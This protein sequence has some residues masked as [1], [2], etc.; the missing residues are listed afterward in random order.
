M[1]TQ[2][3][4][5]THNSDDGLYTR[6]LR[7]RYVTSIND[8]IITLDDGTELYIHGNDGCGGCE[9]GWYWLENVYKQGSR[10]ARIMSAYVAYGE[11]DEDAPSVYT[12]FVMVDGNPT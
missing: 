3:I 2:E 1:D 10:R 8:G 7:G 12:L 11:D 5:L 9:S 4:V 6:L